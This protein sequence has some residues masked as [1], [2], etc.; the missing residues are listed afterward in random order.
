MRRSIGWLEI[1]IF[2][3]VV[4][5]SGSWMY[6]RFTLFSLP[7]AILLLA[8]GIDGLWTRHRVAGIT[9]AMIAVA[10]QRRH[11]NRTTSRNGKANSRRSKRKTAHMR[12][13]L[14]AAM[15]QAA[16]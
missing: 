9:A 3:L 13:A 6:A 2:L 15:A 14:L 7:G 8:V 10:D 12:T 4:L 5:V 16:P 1:L 11:S